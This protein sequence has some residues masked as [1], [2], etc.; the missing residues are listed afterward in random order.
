VREIEN[1]GYNGG[2]PSWVYKREMAI[3]DMSHESQESR[4]S[5]EISELKKE[6]EALKAKIKQLED[7]NKDLRCYID[8]LKS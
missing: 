6:N 4:L 2:A 8:T 3:R 7:E 5:S 1:M